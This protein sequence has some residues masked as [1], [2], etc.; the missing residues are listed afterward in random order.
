[1]L[2][3]TAIVFPGQGSQMVGMGFDLAQNFLVAKH[4]FA[5]ID[6]QLKFKLSALMFEG[7]AD[8]LTKTQYTQPA[9]M[10]V[11]MAIVQILLH[12]TK[13]PFSAF[14][15]LTAGHSLGEYSALCASGVFDVKTTSSL[16]QTRGLAMAKCGEK[17]QGAMAALLGG[18]LEQIETLAKKASNFGVCQIA[19]DNSVGQVVISGEKK[20]IDYAILI[21]KEFGIK[22]AI[23]LPVSGAFHS[24]LMLDAKQKMSE[25]LQNVACHQSQVP[26]VANV[27]ALPIDDVSQVPQLLTSQITGSVLWRQT[28][29]YFANQ[30]IERII[31]I[32]SGKVFCGLISKTC[33]QIEALSLQNSQD[34]ASFL[35]T[36]EK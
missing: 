30:Q 33:P 3:K 34:I 12:E 13:L 11:S 25:A 20:A 7:P 17:T 26:V 15:C 10:A 35:T 2:K 1:M 22:R 23:L 8:E 21:A 29:L 16:L 31:E 36:L 27:T 4:L 9:L 19:N 32:G 5:E 14:A 18:E 24:E 28:N 6:E